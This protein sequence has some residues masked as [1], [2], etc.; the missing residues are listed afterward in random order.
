MSIAFIGLSFVPNMERAP[1]SSTVYVVLL[2]RSFVPN[3]NQLQATPPTY[4]FL[5]EAKRP[6]VNGCV[7]FA[8]AQYAVMRKMFFVSSAFDVFVVTV[9]SSNSKI[10]AR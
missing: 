4:T 10:I 2:I 3:G 6:S 7:H 8:Q 9:N 5:P 1:L